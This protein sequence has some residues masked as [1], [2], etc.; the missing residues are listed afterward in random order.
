MRLEELLAPYRPPTTSLVDRLAFWAREIPDELAFQYLVDGEQEEI[1]ITYAE[2]D[3]AA[4]SV[5]ARLRD[6]GLSGERVLLLYPPGM[7]FVVGLFGCFHA[8]AVAVPA[9]PP[10]RNRNMNRIQAIAQNATAI[11]ALTTRAVLQRTEPLLD[12][13]QDLKRLRWFATDEVAADAS[14]AGEPC[15]HDPQSLA[16]LQYTSGSTGEPKGVMLTNGNM[17][18]N[19]SLISMAFEAHRD[20]VGMS[21]LPTYHDMGLVGG[22]LNPIFCGRPSV[23]MSPM[24]F[25]Q[26]PA[27]WLKAISRYG[28]TISGGPNFAYELCTKRIDDADLAGVDL[29]TWRVAFN[30]AEPVRAAT[31]EAFVA[32]FAPLGFRGESFYPCYGMAEST[33]I[34]T[35]GKV[36]EPTVRRHFDGSALDERRVIRVADDSDGVRELVGCGSILPTEIVRIVDPD[37]CTPLAEDRVGEIWIASESVGQ[38]YWERPELT[39][40]NFGARLADAPQDANFLRSGDLGFFHRGELFVT[41]RLKDMII[42]R[43]VNRYPQDIEMTVESVDPRLRAGAAAAFAVDVAGRERLVIVSEVERR[44]S[45]DWKSLLESIRREVALAHDLPPD[46]VVLVRAGSIPK[47]SSGKIQRNACRQDFLEES[48][49]IVARSLVWEDTQEADES[50][51]LD[52]PPQPVSELP[53]AAAEIRPQVM[54]AVFEC[55][56]GVA[57]ERAGNLTPETNIVALGLDSL[58]RLDILTRLEERF[59]GNLPEDVLPHIETCQEVA[60]AIQKH[61]VDQAGNRSDE[62]PEEY[63]RFD[64]MTEYV[65]LKRNM[66]LL[67]STGVPNPYFKEHERVTNDTAQI[68]GREMVSFSSYNYLGMSGDQRVSDSAKAAV[69]R[70]GTS[71]SASR[72]VSGQKLLHTELE[73]TIAD[74]LGV[75]D[76]IVYIGGHATNETTIGH[77]FGPGDLILHD[78][79]A[80]NSIIQGAILSGARRRPFP[81][82]DWRALDELLKQVRGDYKR[83]LIALEGVYSMDGD[84]PDLPQFVEV[85]RRHRALLMVDEAHSIGTM[86]EHGRGL[87]EHFDVHPQDVDMWMGTLSK[88]FGSCGG[89]IAGCKE[90]IEYL[91]YTAPGF[92]YSVGLAPANAAA[93]LA[94]IH[95]LEEEPERA[96]RCRARA[97]LFL[98]M[99]RERGLDT[100]LG[101]GTPVVPVIIGNSVKALHLSHR[102][103]ERGINVQPILYPAVAESAA[104]LRFFITSRHT[105]D[106]IRSTVEILAEEWHRMNQTEPSQQNGH[107]FETRAKTPDQVEPIA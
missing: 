58:E 9:Y 36:A 103:F 76:A 79:L 28:V 101:M 95:L 54:Q 8:G 43:G 104:R 12:D 20:V 50:G 99:A 65:Q 16:V 64:Q 15:R 44:Q 25:L 92:V 2:L 61:L 60:G 100:G 97:E 106:Q 33:L 21:W 39:E 75:A 85:K 57:N 35:G 38:G 83:V 5:A 1:P 32:R 42:V 37:T 31:L 26:K 68:Q 22:I 23:L 34:V 86:G 24:M 10:R 3:R 53:G 40:K 4:R 49:K 105:E 48:L 29:S 19:C 73:R 30:G 81:H 89:Y 14:D 82:N 52:T 7:D 102:L 45:D 80:H 74:F 71:V 72:L 78:A 77:L 55:V 84:F 11:A 94:A 62:V 6:A 96:S 41:G 51:A 59:G 67:E 87:G 27:R 69:D 91:K 46:G 70:Y 18:H 56:R 93:A 90:L 107:L 47:T 98:E 63:Y 13:A 17:V 88:S 66:R